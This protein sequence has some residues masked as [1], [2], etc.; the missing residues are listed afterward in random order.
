MFGRA[1]ITFGIG[2][3]SSF[4]INCHFVLAR[5]ALFVFYTFNKRV[6]LLKSATPMDADLG[7]ILADERA[8]AGGL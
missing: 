4:V 5:V 7:G 1:T 2:P 3:H 8:D 6:G